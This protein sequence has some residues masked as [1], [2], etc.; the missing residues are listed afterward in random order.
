MRDKLFNLLKNLSFQKGNFTLSSGKSSEYFLDVK[1]AIL[2]PEGH[3]L[4]GYL[5]FKKILEIKKIK[6]ICG[7]ELG[8]CSLASAVSLISYLEAKELSTFYI[9]KS[10][11]DHGTKKM[12]EGDKALT[13][14]M[15]VVLLE[16]VT[17]TGQSSL[18]AIQILKDNNVNPTYVLSV[19]DRLEGAEELLDKHNVKLY[20]LFSIVDFI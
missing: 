6:G 1:Q 10:S 9:R 4:V 19:I 15:N 13:S 8:G 12:I 17:T 3:Y 5:L 11:K 14:N 7:V 20:S 18:N 16:D 2:T